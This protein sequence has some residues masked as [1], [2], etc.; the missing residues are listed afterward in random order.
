[1]S[2]AFERMLNDI[3]SLIKSDGQRFD[4]VKALVDSKIIFI[5]DS[6]LLIEEGDKITRE[7][8]NGL[9]ETYIVL[10][11]GYYSAHFGMAAHYQVKVEKE[12]A[13]NANSL[14]QVLE[15]GGNVSTSMPAVKIRNVLTHYFNETELRNLCCDMQIDY[16]ALSGSGKTDKARELVLWCQHHHR[17][18]ELLTVCQ[19]LRPNVFKSDSRQE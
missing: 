16:E 18:E 2:M 5:S 3:V 7:L 6:T 10:D 19:N 8:P 11:R 1:M 15:T 9:T 17:Y 12:T 4:N 14:T 13:R